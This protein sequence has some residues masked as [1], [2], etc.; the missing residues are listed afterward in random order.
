MR[1]KEPWHCI[2][3][4]VNT[5]GTQRCI[6]DADT[7]SPLTVARQTVPS[8]DSPV[9]IPLQLVLQIAQTSVESAV[10]T[11]NVKII[12][13]HPIARKIVPKCFDHIRQDECVWQLQCR[14]KLVIKCI[15]YKWA[16]MPQSRNVCLQH[17]ACTHPC[18]Y[19]LLTPK[20]FSA[21]HTCTINIV[22]SFVKIAPVS[23][24]I[25]LYTKCATDRSQL[26]GQCTD[27]RTEY[28][29][30][31]C[32]HC[33]FFSAGTKNNLRWILRAT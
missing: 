20:T 9:D 15:Q 23:K 21:M 19:D 1:R 24:K 10:S 31:Y 11:Q 25:L 2:G 29:N 12:Q 13:S 27:S 3:S 4:W 22:P 30:T 32:L 8:A 7:S 17:L 14:K 28:P 5:A 33:E 6:Y 16:S 18:T 26:D